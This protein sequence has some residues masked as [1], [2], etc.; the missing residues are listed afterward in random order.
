M[1]ARRRTF[2]RTGLALLLAAVSFA[3][4]PAGAAV[5]PASV[6]ISYTFGA[7]PNLI[8]ASGAGFITSAGGP[9]SLLTLPAGV[10]HVAGASASISPT[11]TGID[12]I[13]IPASVQN[14][15]GSFSPNG[16][17]ALT[18]FAFFKGGGNVLAQVPLAPIGGGGVLNLTFAGLGAQL[19]GGTFQGAGGPTPMVFT[20]MAAAVAIPI[21]ATAT[22]FDNRTTGGQGTV[23][24][25]APAK[26]S[27]GVLGAVP[28]FGTLQLTYAPEPGT[29]VLLGAGTL[30]LAGLGWRRRQARR[31]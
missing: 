3:T 15:A 25:V 4:S 29:L 7:Y 6:T 11:F 28:L 18:G 2:S 24:L 8:S 13:T 21:T 30:G 5:L 26:L 1:S 23:Q 12:Q 22:A 20:G 17:A 9:G 16:A 19:V 14:S 27:L 10:V 31:G